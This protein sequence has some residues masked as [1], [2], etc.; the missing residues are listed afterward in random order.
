MNEI[1]L[2]FHS[3]F[4]KKGRS[5]L[6]MLGIIIGVAA[7][8]I[9]VA[10]VSGY[11]A[12]IMAYYEKLGVNKVGVEI[13]YYDRTNTV[14]VTEELMEFVNTDLA[15][16]VLGITPDH[17]SSGT[18]KYMA[19]SNA[20]ATVYLGN[21]QWSVCNNYVI[22]KGR[23]L[24]PIDV[25]KRQRACVIGSW[26][27]ES[28]FGYVDPIGKVIT[29][30]GEPFTVV[31]VYYQKDG[32]EEDSMDDMILIPYTH[33]RA[34]KSS[35]VVTDLT[36]KVATD[37]DMD[38]VIAELEYFLGETLNSNTSSYSLENGNDA[39][40]ESNEET[41][42]MSVVLGGIACIALLVGGIGIM[43]IML[44]TV[45]ERTRE[46][47]IKK[48][49]GAKRSVIITQFL[50]ESAVLSSVGG[51]IGIILG[52]AGS[53][54]LGKL[55]YDLILFPTALVTVGAA[56]FSIAIGIVFGLYPAVKA[57]G[58]QPVDALRA[59]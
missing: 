40:A 21:E 28:L 4:E 15:D 20:T 6:T 52:Y 22:N 36:V 38:T 16:T 33:N 8:L 50:V 53:V 10:L 5:F 59:D 58:L 32:T 55:I 19:N 12:D 7:V 51:A 37:D 13:N 42:S 49:I 2:A 35:A 45:T 23:D 3:L 14:D 26:V 24:M 30:G 1:Q 43:N 39:M 44:V 18:L 46:I 27:A 41:A 25:E 56:V 29:F 31:G 47:G 48:A 11:N 57:S 34:L 54:I 17:T 9:L